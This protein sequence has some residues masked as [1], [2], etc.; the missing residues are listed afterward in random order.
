MVYQKRSILSFNNSSTERRPIYEWD[1][2]TDENDK[3]YGALLHY[4]ERKFILHL[5][6][7]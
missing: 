2:K 1:E 7:I 4:I 6:S 3:N 5:A